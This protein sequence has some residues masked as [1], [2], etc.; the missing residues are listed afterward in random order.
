MGSE[1]MQAML[2]CAAAGGDD[3]KRSDLGTVM[4]VGDHRRKEVELWRG[5]CSTAVIIILLYFLVFGTS[6]GFATS[7][8]PADDGHS[9]ANKVHS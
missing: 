6:K 8:S 5:I 4:T 7:S 9:P 3:K 1:S 2:S